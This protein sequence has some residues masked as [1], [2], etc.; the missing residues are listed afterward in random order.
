MND[1]NSAED[2]AALALL[3]AIASKNERALVRLHALLGRRIYAFSLRLGRDVDLANQVVTDTLYDVWRY[4]E[5]FNGQSK[6]S[7]WMIAIAKHKTMHG[8]R[9]AR[10]DHLDVDD[11]ADSLVSNIGDP[12]QSSLSAERMTALWRCL[13][14][15]P[16][17]QRE[18]L[19]LAYYEG[20]ALA[21]VAE[22]Q[23][24]PENTVKTRL[25]HARK[26]LEA[27]MASVFD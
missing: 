3:K 17:V 1:T 7:T 16:E 21:E 18:A 24:V 15:L 12:E 23:N 5:R 10:P 11:F 27:C 19:H 25:F 8:M 22:L 26:K 13:Q 9:R 20:L 6:V 4:P 2:Q 14:Q